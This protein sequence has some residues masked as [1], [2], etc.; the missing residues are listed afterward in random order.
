MMSTAG[1][2]AVLLL[3]VAAYTH[4]PTD[5][6]FNWADVK[7]V[8]AF[9]DS[10]TFVQG[11]AGYA[12]FRSVHPPVSRP[13]PLSCLNSFIGDLIYNPNWTAHDLLTNEIIPKNVR[14]SNTSLERL[15]Q[16]TCRM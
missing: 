5:A 15:T 13:T 6:S 14:L 12:N 10:Y 11:T 3:P 1:F 9:G 4:N 16:L 2:A 8:F 7:Q